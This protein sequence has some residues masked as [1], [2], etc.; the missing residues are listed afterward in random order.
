M[1][2]LSIIVSLFLVLGL[3][4]NILSGAGPN[5]KIVID[6]ST[7]VGPIAKAFAEYYMS[8][9]P[10]VNITVSESGSG[11]G[12]KALING[13]CHVATMSRLLKQN[14]YEAAV[15]S[16]VLPVTHIVAFDG[17]ALIVH[18]SNPIKGLTMDQV[19]SI[20]LGKFKSWKEV[21][22]PDVPI[23]II[24]RDTNSGTYETFE[25]KVL[26][27]E[28]IAKNCE[29]VGSNGAIRGRVQNTPGAIGY[30]GI[31]FIDNSIKALEINTVYPSLVT[32]KKGTYAISRPLYMVTKDYPALGTKLFE[33]VNLYLTK[34]G[35]EIVTEI[36]FI[37]VTNY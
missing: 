27:G 26:K 10:G 34:K 31:G 21:G 23:I 13:S 18:P 20:Y 2:L 7:T 17:I 33:F 12:A 30:V 9:N 4:V 36:G 37:P 15:H 1:K 24:S 5:E 22:G 28:K 25:T 35:Q 11:N 19:K 14:E 3:G 8:N 6:G 29:Y 32:V 16:E